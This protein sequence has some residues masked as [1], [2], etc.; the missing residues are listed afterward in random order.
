VE[1]AGCFS[2]ISRQL[3]ATVDDGQLLPQSITGGCSQGHPTA[4]GWEQAVSCPVGDFINPQYPQLIE[5]A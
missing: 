4:E 3:A 2:L 1:G 5:K